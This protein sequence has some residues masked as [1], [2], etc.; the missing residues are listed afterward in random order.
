MKSIFKKGLV[1]V[2]AS[3]FA[4]C[5]FAGTS[6]TTTTPVAGHTA[7]TVVNTKHCYKN[8]AGK[9]VCHNHKKAV[10]KAAAAAATN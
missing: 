9:K 4:T 5:V 3:L 10:K 6:A 8:K 7:N 1:V 2:L